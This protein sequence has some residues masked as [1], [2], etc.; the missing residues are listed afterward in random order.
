MSDKPTLREKKNALKWAHRNLA[1]ENLFYNIEKRPF[2]FH[3]MNSMEEALEQEEFDEIYKEF[4][5]EIVKLARDAGVN[6][7]GGEE[8]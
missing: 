8:E 1:S 3:I 6:L 5:E 4:I 7:N 2:F